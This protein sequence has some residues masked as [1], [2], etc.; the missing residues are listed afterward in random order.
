[1][2]QQP[3]ARRPAPTP[4]TRPY[5]P[6]ALPNDMSR[7]AAKV[8]DRG[9]TLAATT[10]QEEKKAADLTVNQV[11]AGAAAAATSAVLG[12]FFGATGTVA[13]AALGSVASTIATTVYQHSLDRTRDTITSRI[14]ARRGGVEVDAPTTVLTVPQPRTPATEQP[15]ALLHVAPDVRP[16]KRRIIGWVV[17][18]ALVF[19]LGLLAVTG[20]EWA[21][22]STLTTGDSGTSVGRVL[23]GGSADDGESR[24]D[25][26]TAEATDEPTSSAEPT[27]EPSDEATPTDEPES[28]DT[29]EPTAEPGDGSGDRDS[30]SDG[31]QATPT[32]TPAPQ[33]RNDSARHGSATSGTLVG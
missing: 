4:P 12:S 31:R 33:D 30:R 20:L 13:G 22:G 28:S 14:R 3:T 16:N 7:Q 10:T 24:D 5:R 2:P 19:A 9:A 1:M 32:P 27:E 17:A 25:E 6:S 11:L 8:S 18:T 21:K 23:G 29:T 15:T 26:T